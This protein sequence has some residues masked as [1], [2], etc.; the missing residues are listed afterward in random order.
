M[1]HFVGI[2]N[3]MLT[4][5]VA[6]ASSLFDIAILHQRCRFFR[7]SSAKIQPH[8]RF[9]A[10]GLAPGHKFVGS[11]LIGLNRVP[12]LI[13]RARTIFLRPYAIEPVVSGN[14]ISSRIPNDRNSQLSDFVEDVLTKSAGVG[15]LRPGFVDALVNGAAQVLKERTKQIAIE[16][17]NGSSGVDVD[18]RGCAGTHR[19]SGSSLTWAVRC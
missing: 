1:L 18:P 12:G 6:P 14:K 16:R 4:P 13:Q 8:Q 15:E 9:R 11:E 10:R 19:R 17:R 7:R 5:Q 2:G 3:A